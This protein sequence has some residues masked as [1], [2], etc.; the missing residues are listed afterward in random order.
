MN[1]LKNI[2]TIALLEH[3][4]TI[5][6]NDPSD[7]HGGHMGTA[8]SLNGK[9]YINSTM[10]EDFMVSTILHEVVHI[11]SGIQ[12]LGLEDERTIDGIALGIMSLIRN[13]P[14]LVR[15]IMQ[16]KQTTKVN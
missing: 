10:S 2:K 7:W 1:T 8:N 4:L 6:H 13:N 5:T 14:E 3:E 15:Q 16:T 12:S 9:I 11:M